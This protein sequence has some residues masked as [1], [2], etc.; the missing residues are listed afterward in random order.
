MDA[1]GSFLALRD[2]Q[3]P[4][5]AAMNG[6]A[7]GGGLGLAL[8]CDLRVANEDAKYGS[9][10]VKLGLHPGMA[11]TYILPRLVGLPKATEMILTGRLISGK[12]KQTHDYHALTCKISS[13]CHVLTCSWSL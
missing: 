10:F 12:D 3:V 9:N 2:L 4:V 11:T 5:I 6:H 7:V 1:Y 13:A 8:V